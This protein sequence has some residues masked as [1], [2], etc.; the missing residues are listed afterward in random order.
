MGLTVIHRYNSTGSDGTNSTLPANNVGGV[1]NATSFEDGFVATQS[2]ARC[3]TCHI[4]R[5]VMITRN[6]HE[7]RHISPRVFKLRMYHVPLLLSTSHTPTTTQ[8]QTSQ[9]QPRR[10][11]QLI[12]QPDRHLSMLQHMT[13]TDTIDGIPRRMNNWTRILHRRFNH[14][15]RWIPCLGRTRMVRACV[16]AFRLNIRNCA[17]LQSLSAPCK[18]EVSEYVGRNVQR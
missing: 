17:I 3:L 5:A 14:K 1:Y 12:R 4:I 7:N 18:L 15:C 11:T 10:E 6:Q 2:C 8:I 16:A 9:S 13:K